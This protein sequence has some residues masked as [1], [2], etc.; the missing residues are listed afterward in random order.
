[1]AA[2][3][4]AFDAKYQNLKEEIATFL[5]EIDAKIKTKNDSEKQRATRQARLWQLETFDKA[6]DQVRMIGVYGFNVRGSKATVRWWTKLTS[7]TLTPSAGAATNYTSSTRR[8]SPHQN[9]AKP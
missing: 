6:N 8:I 7:S 3:T 2:Q 4:A 1:V 9:F 5:P